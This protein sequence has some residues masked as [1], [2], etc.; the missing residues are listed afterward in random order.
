MAATGRAH[1]DPFADGLAITRSGQLLRDEL[2]RRWPETADGLDAVVRYALLPTGK[3]VRPILALHAAEAVGGDPTLVLPA[4]LGLEYL[5]VATLVHD[6]IIDADDTR[7]G[8]PAVPAAFGIPSAI[9]A[10][11]HLIFSAFESIV[12][13]GGGLPPER[14]LAAAGVLAVTGIDLCRG[15]TLESRL[16][17]DPDTGV[18]QYL[19]MIR[20]KT[21][22]LFRAVCH[23][24]ALLGGAEPTVAQQLATY[25]EHL[26][27]AFQVRDDLLAYAVSAQVA[28]KPATSDLSNGRP[29]L[30][31]LLGYAA[32]TPAQRQLLQQ[33]LTQDAA[34]E[35]ELA[36][37]RSLLDSS[38]ALAQARERAADLASL[39][40][41]ALS[42]LAPSPSVDVLAEI[43]RWA[44]SSEAG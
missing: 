3:L 44:G 26:G 40:V 21:G 37:V 38:S 14:V 7:R 4:A 35:A 8:R 36:Q 28:G 17:G 12:E 41:A 10:G 27:M 24:G 2:G 19:D 20:L 6:D 11:D 43:A 39:A 25:G 13:C 1:R 31:V 15:Q 29:T 32:G 18:T 34:G 5:H 30:P 9:V 16:A 22:A 23:I 42:P 33:A